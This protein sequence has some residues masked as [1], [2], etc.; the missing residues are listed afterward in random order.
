MFPKKVRSNI[1][2]R[3]YFLIQYL[4]QADVVFFDVAVDVLCRFFI[5]L[6]YRLNRA[7]ASYV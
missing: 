4:Q 1:E 5:T 3:T 6:D 2:S 7:S